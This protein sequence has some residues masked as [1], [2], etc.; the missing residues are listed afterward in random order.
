MQHSLKISVSRNPRTDGV[1][2]CR[3]ISVRE[4]FLC[5]LLGEKQKL[6]ILV[7]GESVRVVTIC[8]AKK[9]GESFGDPGAQ[10]GVKSPVM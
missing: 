4:K 5:W 8:E 2:A 9:E 3:C 6:T 7:P 10:T 1:L